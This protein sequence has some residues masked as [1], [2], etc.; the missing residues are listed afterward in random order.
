MFYFLKI[1]YVKILSIKRR[2]GFYCKKIF[3]LYLYIK[4][5]NLSFWEII[6][7]IIYFNIVEYVWVR[8]F[9]LLLLVKG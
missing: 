3:L 7:V 6:L 5:N 4:G 1:I 9:K 8:Y 2:I